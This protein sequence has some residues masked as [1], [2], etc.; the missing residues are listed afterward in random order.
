MTIQETLGEV[1]RLILTR[2]S[3]TAAA[4]IWFEIWGSWIRKKKISIFQA[5]FREILNFSGNFTK[6]SISTGKFL[7]NFDFSNQPFRKISIFSGK[8]K[9][10]SISTG[11]FKK[12]SVFHAKIAHLQLL[13]GTLFYFS[14]KLSNILSVHDKK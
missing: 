4:S 9:K 2:C 1:I 5:N 3:C 13:L 11:K 6:K 14:S 12:K 7:K 10:N 8:F